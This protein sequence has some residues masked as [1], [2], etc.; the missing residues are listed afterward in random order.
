[1]CVGI[2]NPLWQG[3]RSRHSRRMLNLQFCVSG[4]RPIPREILRRRDM[5]LVL[6]PEKFQSE[7]ILQ[8]QDVKPLLSLASTRARTRTGN[9]AEM[10]YAISAHNPRQTREKCSIHR[11]PGQYHECLRI[12]CGQSWECP[13]IQSGMVRN[14]TECADRSQTVRTHLGSHQES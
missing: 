9:V 13:R 14:A 7:A 10:N 5:G 2:A 6:L 11:F 12:V 8:R 3:K 4:K 1:M